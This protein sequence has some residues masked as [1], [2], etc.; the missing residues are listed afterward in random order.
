[1]DSPAA[2]PPVAAP[3]PSLDR[4]RL[5]QGGLLA[6]GLVAAPLSAQ[7]GGGFTHGVA[8]GEPQAR[9]VLLWTRFVGSA[10]TRLRFEM[11]ETIAFARVLAGGEVEASPDHDW[12]AKAVAG[13]LEPGR[14][15]YY[16]FVA[17]D[18]TASSIGRTRTLP[19]GRT[20]RFR[21]AVFSC[22]NLGFGYFN[23]YAHANAADAFDL[24]VHLGDYFYEYDH[25]TYPAERQ[26]VDGRLPEPL[27]ET[28]H[29]ADYRLRY[30]SYRRDPDLQR[31]HQLYPMVSIFDDHETANDAWKGGAENHQ[32][33]TE[34]PWPARVAAAL[35]ARSEWL[36]VSDAPWHS[37]DIGDLA[38]LLRIETRITARDRPLDLGAITRGLP[39]ER[40]ES[41]LKAFR[42]GAWRDPSRTLMGERQEHWLARALADSVR[43]GRKWQ[44]LAQQVVMGSLRLP[45]AIDLKLDPA[46]AKQVSGR[47]AALSAASDAGIPFNMDAW[48]GYPAARDRLLGAARE[49]DANLVVLSGDSHNA[50]AC[51]L[52][53]AGVEFAGHS[54]TSP[55]AEAY[56]RDIAPRDLATALVA[57]NPQ[58]AWADVA[59]RGYMAV[60]LTPARASCEWRFTNGVRS[61]SAALAGTH[62][63]GADLGARRFT[64]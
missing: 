29:L 16:R 9:S 1:M 42:A 4:R 50:W 44:V 20:D 35:R 39:P 31:L 57:K 63:M 53:G 2:E 64:T 51:E 37:Y 36:P 19:E 30:A 48:D 28:V 41:A 8:S 27:T 62:R 52:D 14:W 18:G 58:L 33:E 3:L 34:G 11:A 6:A 17:P 12:C 38:T 60:E 47:M 24:A 56:F 59:Q 15:Y 54:V 55:G 45:T 43:S 61:R 32:P 40:I 13:G 49:A 46:V 22:S 21:M 23:G 25:D 5:L 26:R 10:P 7:V